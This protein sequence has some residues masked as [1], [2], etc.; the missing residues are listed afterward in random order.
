MYAS[1]KRLVFLIVSDGQS[2][3]SLF[4]RFLLNQSQSVNVKLNSA[5]Y[6]CIDS[7]CRIFILT[8][9]MMSKLLTLSF[10]GTQKSDLP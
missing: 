3:S 4:T 10:F 8:L 2:I 6:A 9:H 5:K 1:L 7:S